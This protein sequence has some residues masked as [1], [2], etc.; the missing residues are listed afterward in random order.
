MQFLLS[1]ECV[2]KIIDKCHSNLC[3]N[4]TFGRK[5]YQIFFF[6]SLHG[7]KSSGFP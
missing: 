1:L 6:L 7:L 3:K 5:V 4:K 2:F